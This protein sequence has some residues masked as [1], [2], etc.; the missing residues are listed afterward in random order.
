MKRVLVYV[1]YK[2]INYGSVLQAFATVK[3]LKKINADPVLL[4]LDGLWKKIRVKKMK[5]YLSSGD[6]LFLFKAKD[7]CIAV[8]YMRNAMRCMVKR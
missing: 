4:N 6:F 5:F 1:G 8:K 2:T 3:M 7:G